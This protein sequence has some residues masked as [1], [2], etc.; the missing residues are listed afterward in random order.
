MSLAPAT[1]LPVAPDAASKLP[2][3]LPGPFAAPLERGGGWMVAPG[4]SPV[5]WPELRFR[6]GERIL[7]QGDVATCL[8]LVATGVVKLTSVSTEGRVAILA[9]VGPGQVF[10]EGALQSGLPGIPAATATAATAAT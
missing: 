2:L 1:L 10:G 6:A 7:A 4:S 5:H 3:P 9:L 8:F